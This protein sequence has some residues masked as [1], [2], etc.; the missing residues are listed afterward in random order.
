MKKTYF[1]FI[2]SFFITNSILAAPPAA[3][4]ELL[5][6]GKTSYTTNC[7]TCHGDKGDG[8]GP[9]GQYL[10]PKPRNFATDKF[11]QGDKPEQI[12]KTLN[13]GLPGTSMVSFAHLPED[14][15]WGLVH[16]VL[17]LRKKK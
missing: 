4:P 15:R 1:L 10:N 2:V 6:K 16:Y 11:K 13:K 9:A 8:M 17:S 3:T 12:F 7:L 5:E 14:E